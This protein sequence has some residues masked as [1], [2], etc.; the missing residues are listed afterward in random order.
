MMECG[1]CNKWIHSKCEGLSDE[2]Y[3]ILSMLPEN[4]EFLCQTCSKEGTP[5]W[6]KAVKSELKL[7]LNN[8]LRMLS[9]SSTARNILKWS[10]LNNN[11]A[12]SKTVTTARKLQFSDDSESPVTDETEINLESP[13]IVP[14][15]AV[16]VRENLPSMADIKNKLYSNEYSCITEFNQDMV[17]MITSTRSDELLSIYYGIL[18][19]VFPWYDPKH[20][21]IEDSEKSSQDNLHFDD[22]LSKNYSDN[23][24]SSNGLTVNPATDTRI[25]TLCKGVGDGLEHMESRLLYCGQNEWVHANCALW[26]SEVYEEIDGSLQ[27]IHSALSRGRSIRCACCKQ[28]GASVG[29]CFKGCYETYHFNCARTIKCYFMHDKTVYC[30]THDVSHSSHLIVNPNEFDI[31]RSVYVELDRR[32]KKIVEIEKV[33]FMVGSLSVTRLG[34]IIPLVSDHS[35]AIVPSGFVCSRLFWST[36]EPW[37]LVSYVITT[38][39]LNSQVNTVFLDKNFTVDHSLSKNAVERKLKDIL[40]WQKDISKT[41]SDII[42][43]EDE[44]EPQNAA[45]LLSPELEDAILKELPYDLLDGISVQDIFPKLNYEELLNVD[46]KSS[47]INTDSTES[48]KKSETEED[49]DPLLQ[50][51]TSTRELKRS[52]SDLFPSKPRGHQRSCSLTLSCKLD[53]SLAPAIKKRKMAP[54]DNSLFFQLLQVDGAYDSSSGSECGSPVHEVENSWKP[55]VSEEPVT[56]ERCLCTYRTQASYKRHLE[57]CEVMSTSDSDSEVQEVEATEHIE[58]ETVCQS[59]EPYVVTAYE[60]F[61]SYQSTQNEVQVTQTF[62]SSEST[63]SEVVTLQDNYYSMQP[64]TKQAFGITNSSLDIATTQP[65][66]CIDQPVPICV[67]PQQMA[68]ESA[69]LTVNQPISTIPPIEIQPQPVTIQPVQYSQEVSPVINITPRNPITIDANVLNASCPN[70]IN[71]V[72]TQAL[73]VPHNQWVKPVIKPTVVTQ[74]AVKAKPKPR[75]LAAKRARVQTSGTVLIPQTAGTSSVI[76]QHLPATNVVPTFVDAFQQQTGQNLQ[77]IATITPQINNPVPQQAPLLQLQ[78]DGSLISLVPNVQPTVVIQ[79]PR[80]ISD[81]L[82]LDSNGSLTWATQPVY[83]GF[84]TIVQNTV[85]QSQQ[86]LPTTVP[87][88]LTA[89]SS[90]STTT[91]VFQTSKLEPVLDVSS[92]SFVLLNSGQLVNSQPVQVPQFSHAVTPTTVTNPILPAPA[93]PQAKPVVF[94]PREHTNT[95]RV[96]YPPKKTHLPPTTVNNSISLPVAPFVPEQGIPTIIVTPTPKVPTS[97][98]Q[99]RPMSRVLPM[100]TIAKDVKKVTEKPPVEEKK[101]VV[102]PLQKLVSA[103]EEIDKEQVLEEPVKILEEPKPKQ[104]DC[105]K[106]EMDNLKVD[107]SPLKMV[108]QKQNHDGVYKISN[109]FGTKI[110]PAVQVVPLKPIKS[111][112]Q[113]PTSPPPANSPPPVTEK[114][115]IAKP[116]QPIPPPPPPLLP[117]PEPKLQPEKQEAPPSTPSILYTIETQDGFR[118]SSTSVSDLWTKVFE[119][120]QAARIAHNMSPLPVNAFKMINNLQLLG[121]KTNGLKYLIEQL[122]GAG[123]CVKYKPSFYFASVQSEGDDDFLIGHSSGAIRCAPYTQRHEPNDMFGWLAS[124]HRKPENSLIDTELLS[125]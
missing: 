122:P 71:Q 50:T 89:N 36:V 91:Q 4:V 77:Y 116:Q 52:K 102:D 99:V 17:Q 74:K 109:N 119:A 13:R 120:V 82:I 100:Q 78:P 79:Q 96:T 95:P 72:V 73:N 3:Q 28:K 66:Y 114:M 90:Y 45:D 21:G 44:E 8:V 121:F 85:M 64:E 29:C 83:Y 48:T 49:P 24:I 80:V 54:R 32:K 22:V 10:P 87:G 11:T 42:D 9:K 62:L 104:D 15:E 108:F 19:K 12:S 61:S 81:Q 51:K 46:F 58:S 18:K 101:E 123:K 34:K 27:N 40:L 107:S 70:I 65:Q 98:A 57:T 38:S 30:P 94:K 111:K 7:C 115:E 124:K 39:V 106:A 25:C 92:N 53:S 117:P 75:S 118:Y 35:D 43:F 23:L 47:E 31:R 1:K 5:Y 69:P 59:T 125:R 86:F 14:K 93:S 20:V 56:C 26:S 105:D 76:V 97:N 67:Q 68:V 33:H 16:L 37:R 88:V 60:S 63:A 55:P 113:P 103:I 112:S 41:K 2:Q 84:E 6:H 110:T